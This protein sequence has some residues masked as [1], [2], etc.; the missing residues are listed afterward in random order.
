MEIANVTDLEYLLGV[1]RSRIPYL[2]RLKHD[3]DMASQLGM[4]DL[5]EELQGKIDGY[6]GRQ[7][8]ARDERAVAKKVANAT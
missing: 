4:N 7:K 5:V 2:T 8:T 3:Q 6:K 1:P